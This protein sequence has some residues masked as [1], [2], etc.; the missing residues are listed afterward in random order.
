MWTGAACDGI[1]SVGPFY[2]HLDKVEMHFYRK[3]LR[4][5]V[6]QKL[7]SIECPRLQAIVAG[8]ESRIAM[9]GSVIPHLLT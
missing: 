7:F 1:V 8:R 2:S 4:P 3:E 5:N 6:K 9:Q